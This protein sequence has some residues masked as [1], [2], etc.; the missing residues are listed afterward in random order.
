MDIAPAQL[1]AEYQ[2][3]AAAWPFI[4]AVERQYGLPPFCLFAVGSRETNLTN[5]AGDL[6]HGHGVW[7]LDDRSHQIPPGFDQDVHAQ[8]IYAAIML[9]GE[10]AAY[11]EVGAYDV[12]NS[13]QPA[14]AG[15]TGHD[16]GPDVAGRRA[17]LQANVPYPQE[18]KML[19]STDPKSGCFVLVDA[20]GAVDT[21]DAD[22]SPGGHY[23]GGLNNHPQ[24]QAGGSL[25][26]GPAVGVNHYDD[27]LT[28][29]VSAYVIMTRDAGGAFHRYNF[30]SDGR[31][32]T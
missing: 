18:E 15:T 14:P 4:P 17:W 32:R 30:P 3:A 12:Y 7:Q 1:L 6:G 10:I 29:G 21:F 9:A 24:W 25:P 11:G 2:R 26:E 28:P 16:Y 22:G 31:Y 19:K 13:G 27:A 5:E 23:L 20:T 8:A